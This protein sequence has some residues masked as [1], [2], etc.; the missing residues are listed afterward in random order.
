MKRNQGSLKTEKPEMSLVHLVCVSEQESTQ[1][2]MEMGQK[3]PGASMNG[4]LLAK[5]ETTWA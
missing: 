2:T 3:Y 4:L 1:R 5:S